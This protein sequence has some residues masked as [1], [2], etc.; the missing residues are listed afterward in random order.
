ME[1]LFELNTHLLSISLRFLVCFLSAFLS[2]MYFNSLRILGAFAV[3]V[4]FVFYFKS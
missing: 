3:F 4:F 1:A 2:K